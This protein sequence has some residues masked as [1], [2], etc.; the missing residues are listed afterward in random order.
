MLLP[1]IMRMHK[2][3][4]LVS[5][6][7]DLIRCVNGLRAGLHWFVL[8]SL[9]DLS[10][11]GTCFTAR[12]IRIVAFSLATMYVLAAT[13]FWAN[14]NLMLCLLMMFVKSYRPHHEDL[15]RDLAH[16][17]PRSPQKEGHV[18]SGKFISSELCIMQCFTLAQD[19]PVDYV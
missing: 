19:H 10:P 1:F 3:V 7:Y 15:H 18:L 13:E 5:A 4:G 6:K 14:L 9:N 8:V 16:G 12:A 17:D 2:G 11:L